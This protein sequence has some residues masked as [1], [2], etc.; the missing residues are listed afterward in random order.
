MDDKEELKL[1]GLWRLDTDL[2]VTL[3]DDGIICSNGPCWSPDDRTFY[4][5]DTF[6]GEIWK[7]D[8][9]IE[10][11]TPPNRRLFA[12]FK[13]DAGRRRRLDRRRRGLPVERAA[14]LGRP[15]AL[16]ARRHRSSGASACR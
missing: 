15:R 1:C 3:V 2:S 4:F 6:Q 10:T 12:S 14:H 11:G 8:Y 16:R 9:D 13:N 5:A 7:Y